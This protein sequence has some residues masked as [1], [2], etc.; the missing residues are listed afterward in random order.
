MSASLVL[1]FAPAINAESQ[2]LEEMA[3]EKRKQQDEAAAKAQK[4]ADDKRKAK[5]AADAKKAEEKRKQREAKVAAEALAKQQAEAAAIAE[6]RKKGEFIRQISPEMV[7]IKQ[8]CFQMGQSAA[9]KQWL[10][11]S[12]GQKIYDEFY[13]DERQHK[14]CVEPGFEIARYEVT[15]G[16][17]RRFVE[18][19]GYRT[20]AEKNVGG[21]EGCFSWTGKDFGWV[22]GRSWR[23]P[24]F[25]QTEQHPVVCVGWNDANAYVGWL[26]EQTGRDYRLPTEVEWE[27]AARAMTETTRYWGDDPANQAV[28][29]YENVADTASIAKYPFASSFSCNDGYAETSPVG[30]FS[31]NAY[32]LHDMLGNVSEWT[33]SAYTAAYN[34]SERQCSRGSGSLVVRGGAW[35][36]WRGFVRAASRLRPGPAARGSYVGFRVARTP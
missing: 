17:F 7:A 30:R 11:E 18:A 26:G 33:C 10:I 25:A 21:E 36:C 4:I 28:C 2:T 35:Y 15:V 29:R 32:G 8:G 31:A 27:Y 6:Q 13:A 19:T 20:D 9:E 1:G 23:D 12:A 14:V 5:A 24:G 22:G 34:G 16:Q 3:M